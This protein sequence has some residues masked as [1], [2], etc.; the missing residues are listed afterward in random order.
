MQNE[1]VVDESIGT[2][3]YSFSLFCINNYFVSRNV[4]VEVAVVDRK[5][6][7]VY[8]TRTVLRL[9]LGLKIIYSLCF[10]WRILLFE[11]RRRKSYRE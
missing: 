3:N 1:D 11:G 2:W 5:V 7:I 8:R 4:A 6:P 10:M 9:P